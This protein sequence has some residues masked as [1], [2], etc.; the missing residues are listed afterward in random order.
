GRDAPPVGRAR[1]ARSAGAVDMTRECSRA[2]QAEA[3]HDGRLSRADTESFQRHAATCDSCA[4]EIRALETLHA[5]GQ[6]LPILT[7]TPLE[8]RRL[9]QSVLRAANELALH[10][11][12]PR[13][14]RLLALGAV[15][16]AALVLLVS[17]LST[18]RD[19]GPVPTA[20]A[21]TFQIDTSEGA[22]WSSLSR[23]ATVR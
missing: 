15:A 23:Q 17:W 8:Q 20:R 4:H 14:R 16:A 10:P 5:V 6:R 22:A 3:A 13:S 11:A 12:R 2:R 19:S 18:S 1:A 21:P 9:R 7:S